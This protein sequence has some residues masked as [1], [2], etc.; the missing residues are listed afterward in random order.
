MSNEYI[1]LSIDV[2]REVEKDKLIERCHDTML[3]IWD[4]HDEYSIDID[5]AAKKIKKALVELVEEVEGIE[6]R[7]KVRGMQ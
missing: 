4:L 1:E 3:D 5:E 2:D 7:T 6:M